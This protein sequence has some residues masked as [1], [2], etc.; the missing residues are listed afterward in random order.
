MIKLKQAVVVEGKYDKIKLSSIIDA[1]IIVTN[2]FSIFKDKEKLNYIKEVAKK[3]GIVI[4]TDSDN[5]GFMIRN[6]I[7]KAVGK[8]N[9]VINVY[10]PDVFGK[11]KRKKNMSAEGKLGVEGIDSKVLIETLEKFGVTAS[12]SKECSKA[13]EITKTD[14]FNFGLSGGENSEMKRKVLLKKLN[15]PQNMTANSMLGAL[16]IFLTYNEFKNICEDLFEK[17]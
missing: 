5:A 6:R 3:R 4:M 13:K 1:P 7:L 9:E 14:L 2:G 17:E 16:N 8:E 10:I 15:L 12:Q 11:E